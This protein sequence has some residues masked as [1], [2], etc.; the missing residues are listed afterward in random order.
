MP[1]GPDV[2]LGASSVWV[3]AMTAAAP[4][5]VAISDQVLA[6]YPIWRTRYGR[7]EPNPERVSAVQRAPE[8]IELIIFFG[9]WC[10]D[11][12]REVPLAWKAL[13]HAPFTVKNVRVDRSKRGPDVDA[14]VD[15]RYVPTFIVRRGG[16]EL[17]RIVESPQGDLLGDLLAIIEGEKTGT[18]SGRF[19]L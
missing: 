3:A 8:D 18:V 4:A 17:G 1:S 10:S 19:D 6:E 15:L 16:K 13:R 7:V 2:L 14:A 11:S 5:P 12:L 9:T